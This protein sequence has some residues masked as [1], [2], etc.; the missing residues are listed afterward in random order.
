MQDLT[1]WK[2]H[3]PQKL[4][5]ELIYRYLDNSYVW[6]KFLL[7]GEDDYIELVAEPI[8]N[9]NRTLPLQRGPAT[10]DGDKENERGEKDTDTDPR[11]R[12]YCRKRLIDAPLDPAP[13]RV[14]ALGT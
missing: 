7:L 3:S 1:H 6:Q 5:P 9:A 13:K 8:S 10:P 4:Q 12:S 14:R 11:A 2:R